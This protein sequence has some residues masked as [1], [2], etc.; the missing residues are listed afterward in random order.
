MDAHCSRWAVGRG[1]PLFPLNRADK[2]GKPRGKGMLRDWY[3]SHESA[4]GPY[5]GVRFYA[6]RCRKGRYSI[7]YSAG[8]AKQTELPSPPGPTE[9][10]GL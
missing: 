6:P 3:T 8:N 1:G 5:R 4:S 10:S 2:Y 9:M 7:S